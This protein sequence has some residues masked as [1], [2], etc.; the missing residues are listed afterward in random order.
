[1]KKATGWVYDCEVGFAWKGGV[2]YFQEQPLKRK[3]D[4]PPDS[5]GECACG[6]NCKPVKVTV[7]VRR[8]DR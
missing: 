5:D 2:L 8:V 4:I 6:K 1:M 7:E 3:K